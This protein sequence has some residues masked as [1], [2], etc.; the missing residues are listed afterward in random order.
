MPKR[1]APHQWPV[2]PEAA[3]H[4]VGDEE[5]V[6][7]P[8]DAFDLGPVALGRD[9]DAAGALDGLADEGGDAVGAFA[10]DGLFEGLGAGAAEVVGAH[11]ALAPLA[12]PVGLVDMDDVGDGQAGLGV[13][14]AHA[15]EAGADDGGAV[16]GVAAG[17]ELLLLGLAHAVPVD[18]GEAEDGVVGLGAGIGE[19]HAVD[20]VGGA[21]GERLGEFGGGRVGALEEGVV[22]GERAHL[23]GDGVDDRLAPVADGDAPEPGH[24]VEDAVAVVVDEPAALR[25]GDDARAA[26]GE[27]GGVGEGV[28]VMGGVHGLVIGGGAEIGGC[29]HGVPLQVAWPR[30]Q[31]S[32]RGGR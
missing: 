30:A 1:S 29:A 17:D 16:I 18:A 11:A 10:Q 22:V 4:L 28:P 8:A 32:G 2:R 15:A 20:V 27:I 7:A 5:D 21:G 24:A 13:H 25:G 23:A 12:E 26:G 9:D 6:V 3:D 19:E 31:G 14:G